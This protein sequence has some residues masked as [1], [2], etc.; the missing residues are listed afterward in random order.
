MPDLS[1]AANGPVLAMRMVHIPESIVAN[2][3]IKHGLQNSLLCVLHPVML[4][5]SCRC[6]CLI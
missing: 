6:Q 1:R 4:I 5:C 3:L 2:S